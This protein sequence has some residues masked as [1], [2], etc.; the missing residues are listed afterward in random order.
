ME[1]FES[2]QKYNKREAKEALKT[3]LDWT[4]EGRGTH[5]FIVIK[6]ETLD[7]EL[8]ELLEQKGYALVTFDDLTEPEERTR[9]QRLFVHAQSY[10][11][12]KG[13]PKNL[14]SGKIIVVV[15]KSAWEQ[16]QSDQQTFDVWKANRAYTT[17]VDS[18]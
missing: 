18:F 1:D 2:P 6:S 7:S 3:I 13:I 12:Q 5:N 16:L 8:K 11:D 9:L 4:P 17:V 15:S 10:M 14:P